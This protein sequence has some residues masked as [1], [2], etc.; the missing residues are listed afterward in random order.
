MD[1]LIFELFKGST[2]IRSKTHVL[3]PAEKIFREVIQGFENVPLF[4][5]YRLQV[6]AIVGSTE[7][8]QGQAKIKLTRKGETEQVRVGLLPGRN[9]IIRVAPNTG[10][11]SEF[12]GD[13]GTRLFRFLHSGDTA[14]G[15]FGVSD[16]DVRLY[17]ER[18]LKPEG[19]NFSYDAPTGTFTMSGFS[20]G[21]YLLLVENRTGAG[22]N[23]ALLIND[24]TLIT[25]MPNLEF[26]FTYAN[27]LGLPFNSAS[28]IYIGIKGAPVNQLDS[29]S[30]DTWDFQFKP[31]VADG[32]V[33]FDGQDQNW[34]IYDLFC[35]HDHPRPG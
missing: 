25:R 30:W 26:N 14:N 31:L 1:Q 35:G 21:H 13:D 7:V 11:N 9:N 18:G 24:A 4:D 20:Y 12:I 15:D 16:L 6:R 27:E 17:D 5:A 33:S 3:T 19:G 8:A 34:G 10:G 28:P 2:L 23:T 29:T 22:L 32:L